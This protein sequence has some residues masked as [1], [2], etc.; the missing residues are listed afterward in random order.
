VVCRA[1]ERGSARREQARSADDPAEGW[2]GV[3]R[4]GDMAS[5]RP[6]LLVLGDSFTAGRKVGPAEDYGSVMATL[7]T[8]EVFS[9]GA[10]G[11]GTAQEL[12]VA[13]RLVPRL[14]PRAVLLQMAMNDFVNNSYELESAS[15]VNNN[16]K[17]RPYLEN[18]AFVHRYPRFGG[19]LRALLV[20]RSAFGRRLFFGLDRGRAWLAMRGFVRTVEDEIERR[21]GDHDGFGRAEA[22]TRELLRQLRDAA[23]PAPLFVFPADGTGPRAFLRERLRRLCESLEIPFLDGLPDELQ[24]ADR[25]DDSVY[26]SNDPHWSPRGHQL[27]AEMLESWLGGRVAGGAA[28]SAK[29]IE[30]Q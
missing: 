18:G 7:G 9:Y 8:F 15:L 26:L 30:E 12:M 14:R 1:L 10:E 23:L 24:A 13:R 4:F 17:L 5:P 6:R 28:E 2:R 27:A 11:Y 20:D 21:R 22:T 25:A 29:T 16:L 19:R 3:R